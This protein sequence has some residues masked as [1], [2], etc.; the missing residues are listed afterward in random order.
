[1]I[2]GFA[3]GHAGS[4]TFLSLSSVY[5][6]RCLGKAKTGTCSRVLSQA[7]SQRPASGGSRADTV[8]CL[9]WNSHYAD[10]LSE[11]SQLELS[12]LC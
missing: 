3:V 2:T 5:L 11:G 6:K 9:G 4:A 12:V 7:S 8:T 1:M 10:F